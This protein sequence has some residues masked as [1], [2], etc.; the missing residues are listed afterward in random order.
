MLACGGGG[1]SP[2]WRQMLAD[3]FQMP[4]A[5]TVNTEGPALGVAILAGVGAGLYES[6]PAACAAMIHNN[7]AQNPI[8]EN[9]PEYAK[10]YEL[11][12]KLY[13]ANKDLF[14]EL[15]AL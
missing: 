1:K 10:V 9:V 6:V 2:L 15:A 11:F 13:G 5:T 4:V 12:T 7:P 14:K 3:V 8:P